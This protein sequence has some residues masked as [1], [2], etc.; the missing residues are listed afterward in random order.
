MTKPSGYKALVA[1]AVI[2]SSKG[3]QM[4]RPEACERFGISNGTLSTVYKQAGIK[5]EPNRL[6]I[7]VKTVSEATLHAKRNKARIIGLTVGSGQYTRYEQYNPDTADSIISD[8]IAQRKPVHVHLQAPS[9]QVI[10]T[11]SQ[12][13][14][15]PKPSK[16]KPSQAK[17]TRK[18]DNTRKPGNFFEPRHDPQFLYWE[19]AK[20]INLLHGYEFKDD[21]LIDPATG[22]DIAM[23]PTIHDLKDI[24]LEREEMTTDDWIDCF[25]ELGDVLDDEHTTELHDRK[26]LQL[27]EP[28]HQVYV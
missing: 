20:A 28:T 3:A 4:T 9:T 23:N 25:N 8:A 24:I 13:V 17:P 7:A 10:E 12:P 1:R 15:E 14:I 2:E 11:D 21:T 27:F 19:F 16:P 5:N 26:Q 18:A 6:K 22:K